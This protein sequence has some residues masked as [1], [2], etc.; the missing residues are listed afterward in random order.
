MPAIMLITRRINQRHSI[1]N[2]FV[3]F[4]LCCTKTTRDYDYTHTRIWHTWES[5]IYILKL[6][7]PCLNRHRRHR[8]RRLVYVFILPNFNY[9]KHSQIW[10]N[11]ILLYIINAAPMENFWQIFASHHLLIYNFHPETFGNLYNSIPSVNKF[12]TIAVSS[13]YGIWCYRNKFVAFCAFFQ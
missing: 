5:N 8:R 1:T 12:E 9:H 11:A 6:M 13:L 10:F 3:C 4:T 2:I 7:I